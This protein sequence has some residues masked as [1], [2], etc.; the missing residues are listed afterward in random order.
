[1][2]FLQFLHSDVIEGIRSSFETFDSRGTGMVGI[3]DVRQSLM[4]LGLLNEME[5][6]AVCGAIHSDRDGFVHYPELL[7]A[8]RAAM[9]HSKAPLRGGTNGAMNG[10]VANGRNM[11]MLQERHCIHTAFTEALHK[12]PLTT[13]MVCTN[14]PD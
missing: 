12:P 3:G 5:G 2:T 13:R 1:M 6:D 4:K 8:L 14:D 9:K 10:S 7:V 11:E